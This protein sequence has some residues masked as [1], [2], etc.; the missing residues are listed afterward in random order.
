LKTVQKK[1]VSG[2]GVFDYHFLDPDSFLKVRDSEMEDQASALLGK[3]A[4]ARACVEAVYANMD[5]VQR[6]APSRFGASNSS[7]KGLACGPGSH[8]PEC[9]AFSC[10]RPKERGSQIGGATDPPS[11]EAKK[12]AMLLSRTQAAC[13]LRFPQTDTQEFDSESIL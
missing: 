5:W 1:Q 4:P 10:S 11:E 7:R 6:T 2:A 3:R 13:Q 12:Y 9:S 8:R